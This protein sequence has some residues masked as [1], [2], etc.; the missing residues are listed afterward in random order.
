MRSIQIKKKYYSKL[1]QK[2]HV[3]GNEAEHEEYD[4][5]DEFAKAIYNNF[6]NANLLDYDFI[7]CNLEKYP[8]INKA[9]LPPIIEKKLGIYNDYF[10]KTISKLDDLVEISKPMEVASIDISLDIRKPFELSVEYEEFKDYGCYIFYISDLHLVHKIKNKFGD[11]SINKYEVKRYITEIVEQLRNS[12]TKIVRS[13]NLD[14]CTIINIFLGDISFD[15]EI[16][17]LFFDEIAKTRLSIENDLVVLGN[18][19]LWFQEEKSFEKIVEKYRKYLDTKKIKLL[20]ND[21]FLI[22][23]NKDNL[24]YYDLINEDSILNFNKNDF[25]D[26]LKKSSILI[27]G[28]LGFAGL[29]NKYNYNLGIYSNG[30][31][32]RKEEIKR[33]N[34]INRIYKHLKEVASDKKVVIA[35]HMPLRNW[36]NENYIKEWFYLSGHTHANVYIDDDEHHVFEDNQ[37]GYNGTKFEFKF[38]I[39]NKMVDIFNKYDDGIYE[40]NRDDYYAFN[41]CQGI[42]ITFNYSFDKIYMLKKNKTYMFLMEYKGKL[43]LLNGGAKR[44]L[45]NQSLNYYFENMG[46]Y[47]EQILKGLTP[48]LEY[49]K[50]IS[51]AIKMIGGSGRIHGAIVDIDFWNHIYVNFLD[52]SLTAY[53]A[54]DMVDKYVYKNV[55]SLLRFN[56]LNL[57]NNYIKMIEDKKN[58]NSLIVLKSNELSEK[59][60]HVE[61]TEMYVVSKKIKSMQYLSTNNIIRNWS[62]NVLVIKDENKLNNVIKEIELNEIDDN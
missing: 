15:F 17:K 33:S 43:I 41:S 13:L 59:T 23:K 36:P 55:L 45:E 54:N 8:T 42:H 21:L 25:D 3:V 40:I 34:Q 39:L 49:E 7:N 52:K 9:I 16:Y 11:K 44:K 1:D 20:Q 2:F 5:L 18:H 60:E 28:G 10:E 58:S 50:E 53:F 4:S 38:I 56:R 14:E 32:S 22:F 47:Q 24:E 62:D 35:T 6:N 31:K 61:S 12:Q 26:V 51:D 46:K 48:Y 19:E 29:E 27:F 37:I 30:I 57:Y